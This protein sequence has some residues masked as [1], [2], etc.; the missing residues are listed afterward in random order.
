MA[1]MIYFDSDM[2]NST[3]TVVYF[4][5]EDGNLYCIHT[6]NAIAYR[7]YFFLFITQYA[8]YID[9]YMFISRNMKIFILIIV[10]ISILNMKTTFS[11]GGG[12]GGGGLDGWPRKSW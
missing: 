12:D 11:R 2:Y 4:D 1:S 8:F 10:L 3:N 5:E 9:L 7:N 6:N